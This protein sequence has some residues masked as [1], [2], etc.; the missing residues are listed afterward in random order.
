LD[1]WL[2]PETTEKISQQL[3]NRSDLHN[4]VFGADIIIRLE[5]YILN[6]VDIFWIWVIVSI[7]WFH[8]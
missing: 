1:A 5:M 4:P 2:S 3:D 6:A 7:I 8:W